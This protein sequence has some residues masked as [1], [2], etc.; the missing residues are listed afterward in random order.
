MKKFLVCLVVISCLVLSLCIPVSAEAQKEV[1]VIVDVNGNDVTV[2][3]NTN[4]ACG[5]LQGV[6]KYD[7]QKL[8]YDS[9]EVADEIAP[10]NTLES[11]V[12]NSNGKTKLA[13]VGSVA[14]GTQGSFGKVSYITENKTPVLVDFASLKVYDNAGTAIS[15]AKLFVV[16]YGDTNNDGLVNVKDLVRMKKYIAGSASVAENKDKNLDVDKNGQFDAA[17]DLAGLRTKLLNG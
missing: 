1:D 6:L 17:Y 5:G 9:A 14:E 4:F 3:I 12:A 7:S 11:T 8:T 16:M 10:N 2:E 13:F 15:D